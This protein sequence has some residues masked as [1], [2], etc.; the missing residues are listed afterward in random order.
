MIVHMRRAGMR[1]SF[2][3]MAV[4]MEV[5]RAVAMA[6]PVEM[7]A[8]APQPPQHMGAE[9][10][11]HDSDGGLDRAG[12]ALRNGV[13]EQDGGAGEHEQRQR[14]AEP[15][16]QPMLDDIG[17]TAAARG[18]A[19]Y[20]GDVIGLERVLHAQQKPQPKNSEHTPPAHPRV[21]I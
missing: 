1:G 19:G 14:M 5:H 13:A 21:Y 18:D 9:A 6:V 10:D 17:D 8:V 12:H 7:H 3:G 11:Q 2:A 4:G 16:G 20:G 15:P